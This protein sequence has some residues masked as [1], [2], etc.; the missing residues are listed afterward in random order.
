MKHIAIAAIVGITI[1]GTV[2]IV[3]QQNVKLADLESQMLLP[4]HP[5]S[6]S[7]LDLAA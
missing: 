2:G 5:V 7:A 4:P 6:V 1:L 3:A